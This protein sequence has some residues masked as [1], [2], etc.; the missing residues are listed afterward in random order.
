MIKQAIQK[1][2]EGGWKYKGWDIQDISV[3]ESVVKL[4]LKNDPDDSKPRVNFNELYIDPL[5]W[6][7]LGKALGWEDIVNEKLFWNPMSSSDY[8]YWQGRSVWEY[9]WHSFIHH[10][11][12]NKDP[13][14]FFK[15]L[16]T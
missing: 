2:I 13:E 7:S 11:A 6:Q 3:G 14:E 8:E 16:L 15:E 12:E 5:F 1:A 9:R 4:Y 10:L